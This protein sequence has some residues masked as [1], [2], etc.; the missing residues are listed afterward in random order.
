MRTS[1]RTLLVT[2]GAGFMGSHFVNFVA[3]KYPTRRIVIVDALTKVA[4]KKNIDVL[5][6]PNVTFIKA[7]IRNAVAMRRVFTTYRPSEVVHF[8]AETHVDV[9]I[10]NPQIFLETNVM[11]TYNIAMLAHEATARLLHI[12]TDEV[13][14]S[15]TKRAPVFTEHSPISPNSPYSASKAAAEHIVRAFHET[16]GLDAVIARSSNNYG[17]RQDRTK[18]IPLFVSSLLSGK[19]VPLY[20][21][22]ENVRDWIYVDDSVAAFVLLLK[23]GVPGGVYNVSAGNERRNIDVVHSLLELTDRSSD[24][25]RYVADRPGH[26]FRYALDSKKLRKLGWKPMVSFSDGLQKTV[27]HYRTRPNKR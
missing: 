23:K 5:G 22:G 10:K 25:I 6:F 26:D 11:G 13:Y 15:L 1:Q 8:A 27:D 17:P 16:F 12:S 14:G 24:A 18:F 3:R 21:R 9:S 4:D 2:G 19:S 7:D 20:G